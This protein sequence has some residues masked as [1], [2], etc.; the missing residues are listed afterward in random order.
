MNNLLKLSFC[1]V[2]V[3]CALKKKEQV[4]LEAEE[5]NSIMGYTEGENKK[6]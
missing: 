2:Y 5:I 6:V 1:Q 3:T 4:N